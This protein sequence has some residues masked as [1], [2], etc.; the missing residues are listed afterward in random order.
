MKKLLIGIVLFLMSVLPAFGAEETLTF[1]WEQANI[2]TQY[3]SGWVLYW[4][5]TAGGGD[6]GYVK[7]ADIPYDGIPGSTYTSQQVLSVTVP[8]GERV[9]K[10]F[11]LKSKSQ[12]GKESASYSNEVSKVFTFSYPDPEAPFN[13][14]IKVQVN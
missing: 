6:V 2:E 13:F 9:T 4:S 10:Y 3:L 5:E 12:S 7:V 14:I 1:Q 8:A 11:V